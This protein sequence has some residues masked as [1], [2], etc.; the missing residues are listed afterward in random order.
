MRPAAHG[1]AHLLA[2][3]LSG[4]LPG[5]LA[6]LAPSPVACSVCRPCPLPSPRLRGITKRF[7]F[8]AVKEPAAAAGGD[9][10]AG[11]STGRRKAELKAAAA[12]V[13]KKRGAPAAGPTQASLHACHRWGG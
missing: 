10:G 13:V 5:C 8:T 4:W 2:G 6:P 9:G 7:K 11:T 3:R 12:G 1:P